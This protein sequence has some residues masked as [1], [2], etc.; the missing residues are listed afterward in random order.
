MVYLFDSS[1]I[2]EILN[3]NVDVILKYSNHP[4]LAIDLAYGEVYY[5]CLKSKYPL[6]KFDQLTFEI[7][8]HNLGN[9]K[10]AMDLRYSMKKRE[11]NFSF[12][13]ALIYVVAKHLDAVLV[14]KDFAFRG[15]PNTEI[16]GAAR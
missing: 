6:S 9:I 11:K 16:I 5:Y 10:E 13:D 14:T 15:L 3:G 12:V 4:L 1:A 7:T 2:I 8:P